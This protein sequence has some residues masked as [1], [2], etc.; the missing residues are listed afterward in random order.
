MRYFTDKK[1]NFD[2]FLDYTQECGCLKTALQNLTYFTPE[3]LNLAGI[4]PEITNLLV[5]PKCS[6][7]ASNLNKT[8]V[9]G[10][11]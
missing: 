10:E 1:D 2:C 3:M 8:K 6:E 11:S 9:I 5:Q 7:M 4:H